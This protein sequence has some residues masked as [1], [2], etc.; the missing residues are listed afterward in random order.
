MQWLKKRISARKNE[1]PK[2]ISDA[3]VANPEEARAVRMK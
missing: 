1:K 2:P 3:R